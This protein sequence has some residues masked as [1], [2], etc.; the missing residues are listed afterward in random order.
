M[1]MSSWRRVEGRGQAGANAI[2][3][4]EEKPCSQYLD[5]SRKGKAPQMDKWS[6]TRQTAQPHNNAPSL[7]GMVALGSTVGPW[8]VAAKA[9]SGFAT[10]DLS[11][12]TNTGKLKR[13]TER[14]RNMA[15]NHE[16]LQ[17]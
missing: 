7:V 10:W 1:V 5:E 4:T 13:L 15:E 9:E 14:G 8:S 12:E 16:T 11:V 2:S 6:C 3:M 17:T